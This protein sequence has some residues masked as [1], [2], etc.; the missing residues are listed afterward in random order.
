MA[1]AMLNRFWW[2]KLKDA[3]LRSS[4]YIM[5]VLILGAK[6]ELILL[7]FK[8]FAALSM[9][10]LIGCRIDDIVNIYQIWLLFIIT[11]ATT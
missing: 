4:N 1:S 6:N 11:F 8:L 3:R 9:D 10:L 7:S 5:S 2:A